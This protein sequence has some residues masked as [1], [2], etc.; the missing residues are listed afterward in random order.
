MSD[1][2]RNTERGAQPHGFEEELTPVETGAESLSWGALGDVSFHVTAELGSCQMLVRDVL[3]L[4]KSS[5]V[6]LDKM[7]GEMADIEVNGVPIGKGEV[8][9]IGDTLHIRMAEIYG[10]PDKELVT[11]GY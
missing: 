1:E 11:Y 5:V 4:R 8:V 3:T 2:K 6:P 10:A 9:V 7:A